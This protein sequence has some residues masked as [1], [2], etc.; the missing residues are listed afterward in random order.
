MAGGMTC[1]EH[2]SIS[3]PG[4]LLLPSDHRP[5]IADAW[6]RAALWYVRTASA[7]GHGT[8]HDH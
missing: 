8:P 6:S 5:G 7:I 2:W 1:R 3:V 4:G